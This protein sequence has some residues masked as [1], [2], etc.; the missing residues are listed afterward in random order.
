MGFLMGL[1]MG[2]IGLILGIAIYPEGTVSRR[3]F[4]K[5]WAITFFVTSVVATITIII[6]LSVYYL[7]LVRLFRFTSYSR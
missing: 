1:F 5:A 2:V 6:L 4:T 7:D 3:T